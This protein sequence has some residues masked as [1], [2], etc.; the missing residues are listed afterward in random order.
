MTW[1]G[2]WGL[3]YSAVNALVPPATV[4]VILLGDVLVGVV[5]I[6]GGLLLAR[7]RTA[8]TG[9]RGCSRERSRP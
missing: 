1:I 5:L 9:W 8:R 2:V 6:L 7:Y 4:P 3:V